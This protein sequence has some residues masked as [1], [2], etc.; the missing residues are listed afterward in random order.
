MMAPILPF[1][2]EE[3][4]KHMPF[5]DN[6]EDSIHLSLF[7]ESMNHF[8]N[9]GLAKTWASI[10]EV[11]GEVTKALESARVAKL[12]GHSLD[13]SITL[14]SS[15]ALYNILKKYED[16]LRSIFI[17]SEALLTDASSQDP[18]FKVTG[19]EDLK[20]KVAPASYQKCNR[21]WVLDPTVGADDKY[22]DV[23]HRCGKVLIQLSSS[24]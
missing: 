1:T 6:K 19:R 18:A 11:R 14:Y 24:H 2:A 13:A 4:W 16:S 3:I 15:G 22:S 20:I 21:C 23:C 17:V 7:S 5:V 10:I 8:K 9:E 12:I